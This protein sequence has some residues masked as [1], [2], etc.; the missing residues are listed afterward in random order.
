MGENKEKK[1]VFIIAEAGINHNGDINLAKELIDAARASGADAVKFQIYHTEDFYSVSHS[2]FSHTEENIFELMKSLEFK[3]EE[4]TELKE[5]SEKLGITF[6]AS[7][8]DKKSFELSKKINLP[9]YKIASLDITNYS[10]LKMIAKTEKPMI[11]STGFSTLDEIA[12]AVKWIE[13]EGNKNISILHCISLYP[14]KPEEMNLRFITTLKTAFPYKIGFSDHTEGFEIT[15]AAVSLGAEIVE[16]HFTLD[17]NLPG[18]DQ[19]LSLNPETFKAMVKGIRK[20]E[21][22]LGDG[23]KGDI[24][25]REREIVKVAR[26]GVYAKR[27][28]KRGKIIAPE[29]IIMKR[30]LK[31]GIGSEFYEIIIGRILKRDVKSGE[32]I[33]FED[34][35]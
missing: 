30:P 7:I 2:G 4:W 26:R 6:F 22:A 10:L 32:L 29:D 35:L 12:R 9:I 18:P 1:S 23:F 17:N 21:K 11:I 19:K 14:P 20:L 16:K 3:D 34:L 24:P 25:E 8:F 27:E 13:D 5:Y 28:L 15:L 33:K 31:D